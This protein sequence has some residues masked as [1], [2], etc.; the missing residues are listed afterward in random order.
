MPTM[1][2]TG[3]SGSTLTVQPIVRVFMYKGQRLEDPL[4]GRSTKH[5]RASHSL[6]YADIANAKI[7]GPEFV[8][9][10]E[11]YKYVTQT[12]TNG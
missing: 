6:I 7:E 11:V 10:E 5:V 12:G 4:P 2:L 9:N 1:T 3:T 8:G